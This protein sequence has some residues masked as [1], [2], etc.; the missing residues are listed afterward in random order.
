MYILARYYYNYTTRTTQD[1]TRLATEHRQVGS[2]PLFRNQQVCYRPCLSPLS[3][4]WDFAVE[5]RQA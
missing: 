1:T 4:L 5:L 2:H 3:K